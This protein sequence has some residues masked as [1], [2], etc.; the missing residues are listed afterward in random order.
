M[1]NSDPG[2]DGFGS[3]DPREMPAHLFSGA[4]HLEYSTAARADTSR[5]E[6]T[7]CPRHWYID[8]EFACQRCGESFVFTAEEQRF[9]YEELKFYVDSLPQQCQPCRRELRSLKALR[10]EY[11]RDIAAALEPAAGVECKARL[12]QVLDELD[13]GGI[14]LTDQMLAHRRALERRLG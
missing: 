9:W 5:Q 14:Q 1:Q 13:R 12:I 2:F 6:F 8:A 7:V 11:D 3:R 10:Q 4:R